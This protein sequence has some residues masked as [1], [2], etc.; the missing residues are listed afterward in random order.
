MQ[1]S[2]RFATTK[3]PCSVRTLRIYIQQ[4]RSYATTRGTLVSEHWEFYMQKNYKL[5][6]TKGLS[7]CH[8]T[9]KLYTKEV[10][11]RYN[12]KNVAVSGH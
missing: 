9:Q 2:Y 1:K 6:T 8:E 4:N 5:V 10:Q 11:V 3:E 12:K 7:Q